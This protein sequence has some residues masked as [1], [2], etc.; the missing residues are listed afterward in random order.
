MDRIPVIL[1]L[2]ALLSG[3]GVLSPER[4]ATEAEAAGAT[5]A[6]EVKAELIK[7]KIPNAAAIRVESENGTVVLSG[8]TD[9]DGQR[10]RAEEVART[11]SGVSDVDNRIEV[12]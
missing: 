6:A 3:C 10:R 1:L 9:D 2:T 12:K 7:A 11:V 8:F 4:E 5:L